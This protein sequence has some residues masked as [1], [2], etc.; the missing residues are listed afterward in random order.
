MDKV[1]KLY[2]ARVF[3]AVL[4]FAL[5]WIAFWIMSAIGWSWATIPTLITLLFVYLVL[6][7]I[8]KL[9]TKMHKKITNDESDQ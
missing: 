7:D 6:A 3:S 1:K 4:M 2:I 9:A 5:I 8:Y